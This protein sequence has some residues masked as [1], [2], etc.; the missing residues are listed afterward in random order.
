M[1]VLGLLGNDVKGPQAFTVAVYWTL[2]T[3]ATTFVLV[4]VLT[5]KVKIAG[6]IPHVYLAELL[7]GLPNNTA[8]PTKRPS[9]AG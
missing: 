5:A 8:L 1:L 4:G 7:Q 6:T 9:A 3:A 2:S